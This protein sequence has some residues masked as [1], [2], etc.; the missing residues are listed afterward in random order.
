MTELDVVG[1]V[2]CALVIVGL[3]WSIMDARKR[4]AKSK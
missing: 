3:V 4:K 1:L 2:F